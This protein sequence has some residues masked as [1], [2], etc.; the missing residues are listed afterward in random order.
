MVLRNL[1]SYI[2]KNEIITL[3]YNTHKNKLKMDDSKDL[4]VRLD[5]INLLEE[6][7]EHSVT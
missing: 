3:P 1:D 5:T 4:Y 7:V 2:Q 6:N